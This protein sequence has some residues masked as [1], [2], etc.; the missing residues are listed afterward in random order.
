[1]LR[2]LQILMN[3]FACEITGII[4]HSSLYQ[5]RYGIFLAIL[6]NSI[7]FRNMETST[8]TSD[9]DY[10]SFSTT[11]L[12]LFKEN[13]KDEFKKHVREYLI[14]SSDPYRMA[15]VCIRLCPGLFNSKSNNFP[16]NILVELDKYIGEGNNK[17]KF[18][19]CL[20]EDIQVET[21]EI[22]VHQ[23]NAG[24]TRLFVRCFQLV[25]IR[26]F[27]IPLLRTEL[28]ADLKRVCLMA[29]LLGVQPH[30]STSELILPLFLANHLSDA[31]EFLASSP[32]HQKEL[33]MLL[34]GLLGEEA[35]PSDP[36][37]PQAKNVKN[38][39]EPKIICDTI[40][41]LLKRFDFSSSM[42]PHFMKY[43]ALG[44]LRFMFY[45]YY[46]AKDMPKSAFYSLIDDTIKEH[47]DISADLLKL[48]IRYGD[49]EGAI[50]YVAKLNLS[51]DDTPD[52][53]KEHMR[54]FPDLLE[55]SR[56][57]V[58]EGQLP[59]DA[60]EEETSSCYSLTV[61]DEDIILVDSTAEFEKC[62]SHLKASPLLSV[63][64]EWK[65]TFG[66]GPVEQAALLQFATATKVYLL[67]LIVLQPL[68]QGYHWQSVGQ[69]FASPEILKLGYGI[70][71]DFKVLSN[72]HEEMKKG[73]CSAKNVTDLDITKGILLERYPNIFSYS[74][75][76]HK[77]LSDLVYRCF[78][79]PLDK[80]EGF[81][82]WAAR[83]LNKSQITYAAGDVRC[84]IDIYNYLN[85]RAKEQGLA[86][87]INLVR[88][89]PSGE[90]KKSV[91]PS[92]GEQNN[93][94]QRQQ[95]NRQPVSAS[96]IL[97]ICDNMLQVGSF[98]SYIVQLM[99]F[100]SAK[101]LV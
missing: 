11:L 63:D 37:D 73:I 42:C 44:G 95:R 43:R 69:L 97:I 12:S 76:K 101:K 71:S 72:L 98:S 89:E 60:T 65:P 91:P 77:G 94:V 15:V 31:D 100:I 24:V 20:T 30:F 81:S 52:A 53:V 27:L 39:R 83:P 51:E 88:K 87:W 41:K 85:M 14:L 82:N 92:K 9:E 58:V 5:R 62:A 21:Y 25:K 2:F 7:V 79:L 74:E 50:Y 8:V 64:A 40:G 78:G 90:K 36:Q 68:L 49:F 55:A 96:D 1:M 10:S 33:V 45:K 3:F 84:L 29:T 22:A 19:H 48:F 80:R 66:T 56:H 61:L 23:K 4:F 34:D 28:K 47:P 99:T 70:K 67:D 38:M 93:D 18:S 32:S 54:I 17:E 35:N 75:E 6:K 59:Q 57:F 13:K 46:I 86:D 26:D 16:A